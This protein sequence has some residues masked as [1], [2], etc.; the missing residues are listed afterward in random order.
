[1][2]I[3]AAVIYY[4]CDIERFYTTINYSIEVT[5]TKEKVTN[6]KMEVTLE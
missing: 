3:D 5:I 6:V 4:D 2:A 1:M